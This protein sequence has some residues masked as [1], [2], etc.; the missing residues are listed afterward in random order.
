[1]AELLGYVLEAHQPGT[2]EH[3]WYSPSRHDNFAT[4]NPVWRP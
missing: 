2:I 4:T 3:S 1:M